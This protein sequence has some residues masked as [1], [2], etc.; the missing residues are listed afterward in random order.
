MTARF[1]RLQ[2]A[3]D[4]ALVAQARAFVLRTRG[5]LEY[6]AD[7]PDCPDLLRLAALAEELGEVARCV[8]EGDP[9]SRLREELDQLAGVA[10]AWSSIL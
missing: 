9:T 6:V 1:D 8:H 10:I 7:D 3:A 4:R 2:V 5:E